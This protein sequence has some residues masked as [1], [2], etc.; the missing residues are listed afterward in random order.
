MAVKV[1]AEGLA[2]DRA[3]LARFRREAR[4]AAGLQHPN[5]VSIYDFSFDVERP[6]LVMA[7]MPG[8]S[9]QDRLD[10][11]ESPTRRG[12]RKICSALWPTSTPPA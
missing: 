10:A 3:W 9:L 8:G 11:G 5:L 12:W 2:G 4:V 7:Y 1:L 6:Y